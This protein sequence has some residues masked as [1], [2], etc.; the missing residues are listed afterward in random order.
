MALVA[1]VPEP[2]EFPVDIRTNPTAPEPGGLSVVQFLVN[3]PWKDRP[4]PRFNPVH[5]RL[6]HSFVVSQDLQFFDHGHPT[7]VAPGIFQYPI[8]FPVAGMYRLLADFYPEG[9][10]P[11]L[12]TVTVFVKGEPPPAPRLDRDYSRKAAT[13][14]QVSL[15]TIPDHPIATLRTQM[16]F[17]IE[18]DRPLEPYLGA[19]GHMLVASSDLIDMMH[20]HPWRADGG[21]RIEF[22]IVFPRPGTFRAWVQFQSAGVVNTAHFDLVVEPAP[23]DPESLVR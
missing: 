7:L 11:Q 21:P 6:I 12:S 2:I 16:R 8:R 20:E 13:N 9:A 17:T 14:L 3:D 4:A 1:G 22:E 23:P 18:S 5:E 10:T 19:W 15:A